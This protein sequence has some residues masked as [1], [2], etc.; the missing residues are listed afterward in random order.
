MGEG[1]GADGGGGGG[2][3]GGT[4]SPYA[5]SPRFSDVA[6]ALAFET[7]SILA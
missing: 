2:R 6:A 4:E 7:V 1:E 5:L 3:R